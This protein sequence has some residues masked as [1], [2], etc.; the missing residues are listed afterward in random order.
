MKIRTVK[1]ALVALALSSA[2]WAAAY[3]GPFGKG[4]DEG[5]M[6]RGGHLGK[7]AD[8]LGLSDEQSSAIRARLQEFW[9]KQKAYMEEMSQ[10]RSEMKDVLDADTL[11]EA[12]LAKAKEKMKAVSNNRID[13]MVDEVLYMRQALTPEQYAKFKDKVEERRKSWKGKF[14]KRHM[15]HGRSDSSEMGPPPP[16]DE[17]GECGDDCP[18]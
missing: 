10:A 9:E 1:A 4:H 3:A 14:G 6:G 15:R 17:M 8:E 13:V 5:G 2:C 7:I 11:D 18:Q 16:P 12:A